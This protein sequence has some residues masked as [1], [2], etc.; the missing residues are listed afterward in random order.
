MTADARN[1]DISGN[2]LAIGLDRSLILESLIDA[3][4]ASLTGGGDALDKVPTGLSRLSLEHGRALRV[5]LPE[6]P[7]SA[8]TLL[9]AQ[10]E[11]LVRAVWARYAATGN[12]LDLLLAPLTPHSQQ[13]AK[14][15]PSCQVM[16]LEIERSGPQGAALL[17]GRARTQLWDG[18]NSFVH[19]GIHP[20]QRNQEG[21]PLPLLMDILK[22]ANAMSLLTLI[23]LAEII[24]DPDILDLIAGL[25]HEFQEILPPLE[26][27]TV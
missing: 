26:A 22:N 15:L 18:L 21:Y 16:L 27:L 9:R 23:V 3:A 7:P 10:Y 5:L 13:A 14:K 24:R 11:S 12:D 8:I 1:R 2:Q 19:G 6:A 4:W 17:L 25:N 20:F